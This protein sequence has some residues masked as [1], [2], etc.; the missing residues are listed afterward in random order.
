MKIKRF[1][2]NPF[3]ENTF[4]LYDKSKECVIIDPGCYEKEEEVELESFISENGL[5]PVALLN[6]HCHI[7][8]ILGNQ[9]VADKWGV[10][11]QM[12]K[13]DLPLLENAGEI[14]KMYGFENYY[15]S[16]YPKHFL[17]DGNIFSFG[18]SELEVLF[19]PGHAPG[20][21]CFYS[22]ENNLIISGDVIF[23]MSIGRTDLPF[24]DY[25]TLIKSITKK[26]FLLPGETQIYCGHGPNTVLSYER[27]HNPFLQ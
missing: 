17:E 23:Q 22:E 27:E 3:Q 8:H 20:H 15:G 18:E 13:K 5:N 10:E 25:D 12:H 16:P 19:T 26:I 2:F 1:V 24:G 4:V 21:I 14:S 6:T 7:D 11:L 9:F